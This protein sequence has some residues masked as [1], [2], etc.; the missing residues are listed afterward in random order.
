[1]YKQKPSVNSIHQCQEEIDN[2]NCTVT[3]VWGTCQDKTETYGFD[4]EEEKDMFMLGVDAACGWLEYEEL[5]EDE[6]D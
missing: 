2:A 1:M 6:D 4:S 3:I 5:E